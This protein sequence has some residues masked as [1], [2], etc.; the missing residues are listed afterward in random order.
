M[1]GEN[2]MEGLVY[3]LKIAA[4]GAHGEGIGKVGEFIIFVKNAKTR[5]GNT[6]KVKL[7]KAY[8]TFGYAELVD[9]STKYVGNGSLIDLSVS[10]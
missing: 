4:K 8:R 9:N 6:Y 10:A 3:E 1:I 7:I 5:I 2:I